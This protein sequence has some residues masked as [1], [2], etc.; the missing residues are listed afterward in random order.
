MSA[1]PYAGPLAGRSAI[2]TGAGGGVGSALC[3]ALGAAGATVVC[4]DLDLDAA[5]RTAAPISSGSPLR[6][7]GVFS[8]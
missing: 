1:G 2:V 6:P 4:A 3:R 5:Q 8:R 7:S